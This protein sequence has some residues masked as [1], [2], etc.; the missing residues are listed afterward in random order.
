[1]AKHTPA[2]DFKASFN[3]VTHLQTAELKQLKKIQRNN[4]HN[5]TVA[6]LN[7]NGGLNTAS[8][9]RTA[10]IFNCRKLF[11]FG[12]KS[13]DTNGS[14]GAQHYLEVVH[15]KDSL[16]ADNIVDEK[17]FLE[18]MTTNN[19]TPIFIEQGG[20]NINTVNWRTIKGNICFVFGNESKGISK[21]ILDLTKTIKDSKIL[22]VHQPGILRSLNVSSCAAIVL[23]IYNTEVAAKRLDY[24][25]L[26]Y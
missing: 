8:I 14:V 18:V 12:Q 3:V 21:N 16:T 22:S 4:S 6:V 9:I 26:V 25:D 5:Y 1:M 20:T 13:F 15:V 2:Q 19:L 17:K 23:Q 24:L 10:C 7:L 11:I